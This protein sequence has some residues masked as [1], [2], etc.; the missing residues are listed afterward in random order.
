ML[1]AAAALGLSS[2]N[3]EPEMLQEPEQPDPTGS[4]LTELL[5]AN[6]DDSLYRRLMIHS[7]L[8]D[9]FNGEDG[10]FYTL[11][12]PGN[13]AMK[14]FI[15]T[16][17]MG[18]VPL[19]APD[20]VFSSFITDNVDLPTAQAIVGYNSV[21]QALS[22]SSF[23][24]TFPNFQYPTIFN[25]AP[26]ISPFLRLTNFPSA[27]NGN[28][29]NN[30]PITTVDEAA[31]N[32]VIHHTAALVAPSSRFLW[33]RIDTDPQLTY[34]RAAILRADSAT[35]T[36][37]TPGLLQGYLMNIGANF[38]V[39][40]PTDDAFRAT[41]TFAITQALINMGVDPGTAAA[42][43]AVLAST[44]DVFQNPLLYGTLTAEMVTGFVAY[45]ITTSRAFTNNFPTTST[46]YPIT[47][48]NNFVA[49]PGIELQ[50]VMGA[51]FAIAATVKG[52]FNTTP[53]NIQ[54]N[55]SPLMPDPVGT[56]DQNYHN[57]VLHKIDQV[58]IPQPF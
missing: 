7:G 35:V 41:L 45:H 2:C 26:S 47:L 34:L 58:L 12:V 48:L 42:Q 57:G 55:A 8:Y 21:P 13:N 25:P 29:L 50:A 19:N 38:T 39:F 24:T 16:V 5:E 15:N 27:R 31:R 54:I 10:N 51:P 52:L 44:P 20:A 17:S 11:F 46:A 32:G 56:S 53:A 1:V 30:V 22:S 4:T 33:D 3:K 49:H 43:A 14:M 9:M 37:T 40:A 23:G 18:A 36:A 28:W 6:P